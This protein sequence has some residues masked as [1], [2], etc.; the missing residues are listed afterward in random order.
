[1]EHQKKLKIELLVLSAALVLTLAAVGITARLYY[2]ESS[3]NDDAAVHIQDLTSEV[4][5]LNRQIAD[6]REEV[7][8]AQAE[9]TDLHEE[10][11]DLKEEHSDLEAD[12]SSLLANL[13]DITDELS[14][15]ETELSDAVTELETKNRRIEALEKRLTRQIDRYDTAQEEMD[16]LNLEIEDLNKQIAGLEADIVRLYTAA[17]VRSE[18]DT[19]EKTTVESAP[20][21]EPVVESEPE[22][23]PITEPEPAPVTESTTPEEELM[24]LLQYGAP[25]RWYEVPGD[26]GNYYLDSAKIIAYGYYDLTT[27]DTIS[28]HADNIYYSASLIKAPYIYSVLLEL[29]EFEKNAQRDEE[30]NIVY[31]EGEEKYNLD[32]IW[33]YD[34]A[35]M[36]EEGSGE[37]QE[38]PDGTQ[39]TWRELFAYVLLYSDN[40]AW[41]QIMD[42]FGYA[43]FYNLVG[44][45][46]IQGT[47]SDFMDLSVSDCIKFLRE[48]YEFFETGDPYALFMKENMMN[49]R[50]QEM[51]CALYP[52]GTAAHKYGWDTDAYHDMAIIYDEHPYLLVIMTDLHDGESKDTAYINSI[53][54][55]TKKI[56]AER[57]SG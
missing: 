51:I 47:S 4:D 52:A 18:L 41:H 17:A 56:H 28:Y 53:V 16:Q 34:S 32:E 19:A 31:G 1:M 55:V 44:Q 26:P 6:L 11:T 12:Y 49:S 35:T 2:R 45:L 37:I 5:E 9:Y 36:F 39:M 50:H 14:A 24:Y 30:G 25:E 22:P 10:H 57:Y 38:M 27:G 48:I 20:V 21:P 43:S 42:R 40:V 15:K 33:T 23:E 13:T 7:T 3:E 8:E 29:S 54:E 46:G